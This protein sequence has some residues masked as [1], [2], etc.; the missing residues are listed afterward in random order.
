MPRRLSAALLGLSLLTGTTALAITVTTAPPAHALD[1]GLAR[2]PPM[3][4]N[5]WNAFGCNV[6]EKLITDTADYFVSSGLKDAAKIVMIA[7][8]VQ[9]ERSPF[10]GMAAGS[11]RFEEGRLKAGNLSVP[12]GSLLTSLDVPGVEAT[13]TSPKNGY[14]THGF[15]SFGSSLDVHGTVVEFGGPGTAEVVHATERR[16]ELAA[17]HRGQRRR[18]ALPHRRL[19]PQA[20]RTPGRLTQDP[21]RCEALS[22]P[23]G[24]ST[25]RWPC[26][27]AGRT[28]SRRR[29]TSWRWPP[30]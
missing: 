30:S 5:D 21:Q 18:Q 26:T 22:G 15:R 4:F 17:P 25:A 7:L 23:Y 27:T 14:K 13:A 3:G 12:F 9:D 6:D 11:V 8:A 28:R 24:R 2:A 29:R 10:H 16:V 20:R 19:H 1:D